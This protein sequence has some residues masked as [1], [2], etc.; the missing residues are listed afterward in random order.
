[1][2]GKVF[3]KT[4]IS[5]RFFGKNYRFAPFNLPGFIN[6]AADDGGRGLL[7]SVAGERIRTSGTVF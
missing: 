6:T 1:M 2:R 7:M 3:N 4:G 5:L